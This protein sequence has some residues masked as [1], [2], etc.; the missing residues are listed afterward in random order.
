MSK[1]PHIIKLLRP[2]QWIKNSFVFLPLFLSGSVTDSDALMATIEA[3]FL[4]CLTSSSIYCINDAVDA[5]YDARNPDKC[6]RP[7]ASGIL[8]RQEAVMI[9]L[10]LLLVVGIIIG[11]SGV[12]ALTI[13]ALPLGSYFILNLGYSLYLK[14]I[15]VVDVTV[16]AGCFLLRIWAGALAAGIALTWWT[17]LLVFLL[18]LMLAIGKR[19][20]EAWLCETHGIES[21][22][23]INKYNVKVLNVMLLITGVAS[24]V[25]YFLWSESPY[26]KERY[27]NDAL[28]ATTIFVAVG[29]IRYLWIL[30]K[31]DEGG[32]PTKVLISD[33]LIQFDVLCWILCVGWILYF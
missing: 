27:H 31:K 13:L 14:R 25:T 6:N 20:H 12:H 16:I 10:M 8:S 21:R 30:L 19:R 32:S 26:V 28:P 23:N 29:I 3:F 24:V 9:A 18:T 4:F 17:L 15:P 2:A 1:I 5:P 22:S 7:V 11:F 33:R